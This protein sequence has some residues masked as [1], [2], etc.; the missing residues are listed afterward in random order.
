MMVMMA[1]TANQL[2]K[3]EGSRPVTFLKE[4]EW[5]M[6]SMEVDQAGYGTIMRL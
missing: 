5:L 3:G 6:L 1:M 2:L 4:V